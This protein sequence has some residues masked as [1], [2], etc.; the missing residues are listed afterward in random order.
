MLPSVWLEVHLLQDSFLISCKISPYVPN[1]TQIGYL[2]SGQFWLVSL[3]Y[4]K[5]A[6]NNILRN[7]HWKDGLEGYFSTEECKLH[8][9][10]NHTAVC[11][12]EACMSNELLGTCMGLQLNTSRL[13]ALQLKSGCARRSREDADGRSPGPRAGARA[14]AAAARP[15]QRPRSRSSAGDAAEP[16]GWACQI[17]VDVCRG[18]Q[19][20]QGRSPQVLLPAHPVCSWSL[21]LDSIWSLEK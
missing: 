21:W 20:W 5:P 8:F 4:N 18:W 19:T 1:M 2:H 9:E 17:K 6:E 3:G 7:L 14:A 16:D 13:S 12:A 11:Y 10:F 15:W